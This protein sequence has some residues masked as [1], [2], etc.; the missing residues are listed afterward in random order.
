MAIE[1][2]AYNEH[3]PVEFERIAGE[4]R[5][6]LIGVPSATIEHVGSTAVPGLGAK[7]ILDI[8]IIVQSADVS[9]AI[10]ALEAAGY[11][12]RGDLGVAG[13]EA[14]TPPDENPRRNVYVCH[15]G[16]LSVRNHVAVRD[17]LRQRDDLRD[18]YAALKCRLAADPDMDISTYI[19]R[20]S[21]VL[22]KVLAESPLVTAEERRQINA[23]NRSLR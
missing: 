11:I 6:A 1:V 23:L 21:D 9:M 20:K 12:H 16:T 13:R 15:A 4:L 17:V 7:P 5:R 14:L 19:A 10:A 22:Q 3:W 18:E 8:D 2:V